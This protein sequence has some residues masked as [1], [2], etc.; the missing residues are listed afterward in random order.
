MGLNRVHVVGLSFLAV[1]FVVLYVY[2]GI[3]VAALLIFPVG[4][5]LELALVYLKS[6]EKM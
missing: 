5:I 2:V 6:K 1:I 4:V 3:E